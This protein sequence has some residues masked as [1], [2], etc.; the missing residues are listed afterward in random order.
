MLT[1]QQKQFI[2]KQKQN[3]TKKE[4]EAGFD[5]RSVIRTKDGEIQSEQPYFIHLQ[6][7]TQYFERPV[8][9]G[10]LFYI[11]G[12]EAGRLEYDD[13]GKKSIKL[14][15]AHKNYEAPQDADSLLFEKYKLAEQQN[16]A[17]RKELD[18]IKK[19]AQIKEQEVKI[20]K[21]TT[22]H[23]AEVQ[24]KKQEAKEQ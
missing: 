10:N 9:S 18:A 13:T 1:E 22:A 4:T 21:Q 16:E 11:T 20:A 3:Q 2:Q 19:E 8:G 7:S 23:K 24:A 17:M 15:E 5:L 14:G 6:G 12:E